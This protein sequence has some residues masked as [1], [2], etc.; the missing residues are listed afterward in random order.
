MWTGSSI[1]AL[2]FFKPAT[3]H[4]AFHPIRPHAC[5]RRC[6]PRRLHHYFVSHSAKEEGIGL[7]EVPGVVAVHLFVRGDGTMIAAPVQRD[8]DGV[9]K[10]SHCVPPGRADTRRSA[11]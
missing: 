6:P 10:G 4:P 7:G 3:V 5:P 8:V 2:M 1:D 11:I 9:P